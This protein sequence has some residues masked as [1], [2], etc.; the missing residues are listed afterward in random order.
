MK[1]KVYLGE[2]ELSLDEQIELA[3]FN[4][5]S[6]ISHLNELLA[7]RNALDA[8]Y[9]AQAKEY[10]ERKDAEIDAIAMKQEKEIEEI[11]GGF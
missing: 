6:A 2:R 10:Q 7:E 8:H 9:D 5:H 1:S 4:M 3:E 11:I